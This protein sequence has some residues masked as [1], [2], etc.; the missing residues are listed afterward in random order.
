[1]RWPRISVVT[2]SFNHAEFLEATLRSVQEQDY[3]ALEHIVI[4]GGSSDGSVDIIRRHAAHLAD[5]VSEP[6]HGQ[7]HALIKGFERATGDVLC[8]LNSDDVFEPGT[9]RRVGRL[10]SSR[11]DVE[12]VFGDSLWIHP[13]GTPMRRRNEMPFIKW[14]WLYAHNYIAQ[15][16]A[17]WRAE[18]YRRVGGLDPAYDLAMDGDLFA[19]FSNVTRM[20][21]LPV[22]LARCRM[23]PEQRNK[24]LRAVSLVEEERIVCRELGRSPGSSSAGSSGRPRARCACL[25]VRALCCAARGQSCAGAEAPC[26]RSCSPPT[27]ASRAAGPS[28]RSGGTG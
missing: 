15:P 1:M 20:H 21:H 11:P 3:P 6:D 14:V 17:F 26:R 28:P 4:D 25:T 16:A 18:L 23:Y 5:W 10:F 24:R 13:D 2:P 27:P 22:T 12:F 7:T 19:R 9:L 8:W